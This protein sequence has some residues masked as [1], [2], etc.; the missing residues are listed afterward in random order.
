VRQSTL[1]RIVISN[2]FNPIFNLSLEEALV[3][4]SNPKDR[5]LFLWQNDRTVVIGRNQNPWKECNIRKLK[6]L[7]IR[8]VRR[9]SGGGAVYHDLG[10]LNFTFLSDS[11]EIRIR[12]NIEFIIGVLNKFG[13]DAVFS[14]KNDIIVKGY[15]VSGSAYYVEDN[16]LCH[17]GTL[18][19]DSDLQKLS[20]ILTPSKQKLA[21]KG[22]DSVAAR[23]INMKELFH[24]VTVQKMKQ[25][26]IDAFKRQTSGHLDTITF[27]DTETYDVT[28]NIDKQDL[29][30]R[31]LKDIKNMQ[32]RYSS[33][34]WTFGESPEF[35]AD[36]SFRYKWGGADLYLQVI[37]GMIQ[38]A[39]VCSDALDVNL[40]NHLQSKLT[41]LPYD[42]IVLTDCIQNIY[43]QA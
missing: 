17:H 21:S 19:I 35:E 40:P 33:W 4:L 30:K 7:D 36:F 9:L 27:Q 24:D 2:S 25:A 43:Q 11:K 29:K 10:N 12:E 8:L 37:D 28:N 5:V 15:K 32:R 38:S 41:G 1:F 34:E 13:I 20:G 39:Q 14:G 6:D 23:V 22:V 18:L 16:I 3:S 42:E 31:L 26:L